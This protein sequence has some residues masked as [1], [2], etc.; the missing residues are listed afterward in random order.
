ME[1]HY[2]SDD[3]IKYKDETIKDLDTDIDDLKAEIDNRNTEI[4]DLKADL[5]TISKCFLLKTDLIDLNLFH[6]HTVRK[7]HYI[8]DDEIKSKDETIKDLKV[9]YNAD[10]AAKDKTIEDLKVKYNDDIAAKDKTIEDLEVKLSKRT[11]K[12]CGIAGHYSKKCPQP[13][14][15]CKSTDHKKPTCPSN[16][17]SGSKRKAEDEPDTEVPTTSK[18]PK[19]VIDDDS[20]D[21]IAIAEEND[22]NSMNDEVSEDDY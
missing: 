6:F 1:K 2:T 21:E 11:C 14:A 13:C 16:N 22:A 20:E 9:K 4:D 17:S 5:K 12:N 18:K 3:E 7:K 10:I 15:I 19:V 8:S